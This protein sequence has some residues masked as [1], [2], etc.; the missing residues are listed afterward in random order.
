MAICGIGI[1]ICIVMAFV[2]AFRYNKKIAPGIL[3]GIYRLFFGLLISI[4]L[5]PTC[6][7]VC[8]GVLLWVIPAEIVKA[9]KLAKAVKAEPWKFDSTSIRIDPANANNILAYKCKKCRQ[10]RPALP[11]RRYHWR[12]PSGGRRRR[13]GKAQRVLLSRAHIRKGIQ[14][15]GH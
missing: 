3:A 5:V 13:A 9:R 8:F 15:L 1:I 7:L 14:R 6:V 10:V 11:A 4:F 12:C 2:Y